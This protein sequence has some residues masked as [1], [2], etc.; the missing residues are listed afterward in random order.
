MSNGTVWK[1]AIGVYLG[2]MGVVLSTITL[3]AAMDMYAAKRGYASRQ[4]MTIGMSRP[5]SQPVRRTPVRERE[6]PAGQRCIGGIAFQRV[7]NGWVQTST[8]CPK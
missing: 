5:Q 7:D 1:V 3:L 2:G 6:L 4:A 8:R